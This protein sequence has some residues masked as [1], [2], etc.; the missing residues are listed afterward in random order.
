MR[1]HAGRQGFGKKLL[2]LHIAICARGAFQARRIESAARALTRASTSLLLSASRSRLLT[3][4]TSKKFLVRAF[5]KA[6][7]DAKIEVA[8]A[9]QEL[10]VTLMI[11][12]ERSCHKSWV[13]QRRGCCTYSVRPAGSAYLSGKSRQACRLSL[14]LF[15]RRSAL[16]THRVP[17]AS[18]VSVPS[19]TS[20][21]RCR[22][23]AFVQRARS[24]R[25]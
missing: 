11:I 8:T 7:L 12:N 14:G 13:V 17:P 10:T 21:L 18:L 19:S 1:R 9:Q 15:R 4:S 24:W 16:D 5:R 22:S 23:T 3:R 6:W 25:R 2:G 20:C